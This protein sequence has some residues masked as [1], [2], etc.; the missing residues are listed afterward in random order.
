VS[1]APDTYVNGFILA[2]LFTLFFVP[3]GFP[4]TSLLSIAVT[5]L[6]TVLVTLM[7]EIDAGE[8]SIIYTQ[9]LAALALGMVGF[10]GSSACGGAISCICR[11]SPANAA[12]TTAC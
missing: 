1:D 5:I 10:T 8:R 3:L 6:F 2:I 12:A 11:T 4:A 7:R 9:F